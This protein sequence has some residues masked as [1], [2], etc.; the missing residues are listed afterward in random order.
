M[1]GIFV[2]Y[3]NTNQIFGFEYVPMEQMEEDLF[4]NTEFAK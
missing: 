4:G 2:A 1:D 3:H